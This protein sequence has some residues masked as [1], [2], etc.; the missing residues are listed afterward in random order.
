M[1]ER[2]KASFPGTFSKNCKRTRK[3]AYSYQFCFELSLLV[4]R[5]KK[6][7]NFYMHFNLCNDT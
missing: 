1:E 6:I 3:F 5:Y 2:K 4:T 7:T